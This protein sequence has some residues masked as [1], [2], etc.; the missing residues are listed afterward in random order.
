MSATPQHGAYDVV[1]IGGAMIGS[2]VA[3]WLSRDTA[4]KGRVLVV[5]RDLQAVARDVRLGYV[6]EEAARR[7]YGWEP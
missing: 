3:W 4:F 1:I 6:S 2:S 7:D 5:E